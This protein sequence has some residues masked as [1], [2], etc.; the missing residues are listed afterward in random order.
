[1]SQNT[2]RQVEGIHEMLMDIYA[3]FNTNLKDSTTSAYE[4]SHGQYAVTPEVVFSLHTENPENYHVLPLCDNAGF[5]RGWLQ[6]PNKPIFKCNC[7]LRRT[8]HRD[9]HDEELS[10][11]F[12]KGKHTYY[13]IHS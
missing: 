6:D 8:T 11:Y 10:L 3:W 2:G 13:M 4:I 9:I 5:N 7:Q 1:M 12:C